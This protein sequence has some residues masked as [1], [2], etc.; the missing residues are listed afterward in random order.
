LL[1]ISA[2][3]KTKE[4]FPPFASKLRLTQQQKQYERERERE[5][6]REFAAKR[7]GLS[8]GKDRVAINVEIALA[9][10]DRFGFQGFISGKKSGSK[11]VSG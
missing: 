11:M 3:E 7:E 1:F 5:R 4:A 9:T 10:K 6:E 2:Y 8:G